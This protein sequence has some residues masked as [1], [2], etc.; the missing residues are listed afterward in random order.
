M[1]PW[2]IEMIVDADDDVERAGLL[3]RSGDDHA[4]DAAGEV[5]V[6]LLGLEELAGA[7]EHHI[8]AKVAPGDGIR[9]SVRR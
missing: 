7:F 4:L 8:A 1:L 6:E 5:A 3:H 2:L 9:A